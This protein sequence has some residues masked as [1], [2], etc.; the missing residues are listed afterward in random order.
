[1]DDG[2]VWILYGRHGLHG[3]GGLA[4]PRVLVWADA[5]TMQGWVWSDG[6]VGCFSPL[7]VSYLGMESWRVAALF[8][9]VHPSQVAEYAQPTGEPWREAS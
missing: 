3:T 1:M 6:A 5:F 2:Y 8:L 7:L 4:A 9:D